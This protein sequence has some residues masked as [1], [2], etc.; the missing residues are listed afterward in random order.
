MTRTCARL[1]QAFLV[2]LVA[3]GSAHADLSA[4]RDKL[5][6]GEYKAALAELARVDS[7]DRAAA[8]IVQARAQLATG[9]HAG[10]EATLTPLAQGKDAA[11]AELR[12]EA[13][14]VLAEVRQR[15]GR[16]AEARADP[17]RNRAQLPQRNR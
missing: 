17:R 14:I 2:I 7:K 15:I 6:A 16:S 11:S 10:A 5:T 3:A 1:C 9:D 13:R 12:A 8:R 4:A